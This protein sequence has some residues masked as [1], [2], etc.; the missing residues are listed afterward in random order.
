MQNPWFPQNIRFTILIK[1]LIFKRIVIP[2]SELIIF[3]SLYE[4]NSPILFG[5]IID[6]EMIFQIKN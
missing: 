6:N 4:S 1:N 5:Q 3:F 2:F